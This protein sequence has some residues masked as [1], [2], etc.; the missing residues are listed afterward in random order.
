M[1]RLILNEADTE[2]DFDAA[3]GLMDYELCEAIHN[4]DADPNGSNDRP[5]DE[6]EYFRWYCR[7]HR[8]RYN[9]EF[10]PNK[11]NPTW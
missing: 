2:I 5:G 11:R 6:Q 8:E 1:T 9:E 10:G 3:L 4:G 7:L